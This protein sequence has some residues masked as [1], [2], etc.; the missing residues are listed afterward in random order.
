LFRQDIENSARKKKSNIILALDITAD[1]PQQLLTRSLRILNATHEHLCALK[2]NRQAVLPLCLFNGV[3][4]I[5]SRAKELKLPTIMDAK[6]NDI[7]N[8]NR[9]IAEYYYKAGFDAVI[10]SPF[11]GWSEGL[12]PVFEVARKTNR[13]V[14]VLVYMSHKGAVEGYGQMVHDA[15]TGQLAPQYKVFAEKA[16]EWKADGAVVGATYPE[17]IREINAILKGKV[18]IYSPGVGAQGGDAEAAVKAGADYLIVGRSIVEAEDPAK[19]AEQIR[20]V[21]WQSLKRRGRKAE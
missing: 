17:K 4:K 5:I 6:I 8:T 18:A 2:L 3:Q 1:R 11:V 12:Q 7:G 10:A 19:K 15:H 16:L 14:I 21:A 13:G 9:A 20:Y